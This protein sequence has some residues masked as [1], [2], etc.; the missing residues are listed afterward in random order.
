MVDNYTHCLKRKENKNMALIM[1]FEAETG[2]DVFNPLTVANAI[3]VSGVFNTQEIR[4]I[5]D[6][7]YSRGRTME[8]GKC[9]ER[10]VG[11]CDK[12]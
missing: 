7:L 4:E 3:C 12:L 2:N 6:A 10:C 1:K 11:K 9:N 8:Y 5:A